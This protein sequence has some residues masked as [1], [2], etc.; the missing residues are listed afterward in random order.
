MKWH[1]EQQPGPRDD[2]PQAPATER[3]SVRES[4]SHPAAK[5]ATM[6]A[7]AAK[8][9]AVTAAVTHR[10]QVNDGHADRA[11]SNIQSLLLQLTDWGLAGVVLVLPFVMGGRLAVGHIILCGLACIIAIAWSLH[12]FL[13]R[14][15][16]YRWSGAEPILLAGVGLVALQIVSLPAE[17]LERLSPKIKELIPL[18]YSPEHEALGLPRWTTLSLVPNET[19]G[20]LIVLLAGVLVL[21]VCLQ[22]LR[23]LEDLRRVLTWCAWSTLLMAAFG[24]V[25]LILANGKFY[26]F[27]AHPMT[28]TFGA[29]KGAFTNANHYANFIAMGIPIWLWMLAESQAAPDEQTAAK[30]RRHKHEEWH[31]SGKKSSMLSGIQGFVAIVASGTIGLGLLLSQSRGGLIVGCGGGMVTLALLWMQRCLAS[32]TAF[33]MCCVGTVAIAG[34]AL[35]GE[36]VSNGIEANFHQL[37]AVDLEQLD[38]GQVRRQIWEAAMLGNAD[39]PWIGTGVS[40]HSEVYWKYYNHPQ[41]GTEAS[42]AESGYFQIA[43]EGGVTGLVVIGLAI[44]LAGWWCISG[45]RRHWKSSEG[46]I[47]SVVASVLI[48][49]LVHSITDFVW[50]A[51]GC[52]ALVIVCAACARSVATL[53]RSDAPAQ[54]EPNS[55]WAFLTSTPVRLGWGGVAVAAVA[56]AGWSL[57]IKMAQANAEENWFAFM[58]IEKNELPP[59]DEAGREAQLLAETKYLLATVQ[60]DPRDHRAQFRLAQRCLALF[61]ARQM[62][63]DSPFPLVHFRD[64]ALAMPSEAREEWLQRPAVIGPRMKYLDA[65]WNCALQSLRH[66]PLQSRVYLQLLDIGWLHD[67]EPQMESALLAQAQAARP[68][69]AAVHLRLGMIA[70]NEQQLEEG[71]AHFQEA[72][73]R[74]VRYRLPMLESMHRQFPANFFLENFDLDVGLLAI[75]QTLYQDS[76]DRRGYAQV[77]AALAA[78]SAENAAELRGEAAINEWLRAFRS[79]DELAMDQEADNAIRNAFRLNPNS[80]LLRRAMAVWDFDH[81]RYVEAA[82]HYRWCYRQDPSDQAMRTRADEATRLAGGIT[83]IGVT[84]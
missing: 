76:E 6:P 3:Q 69:D 62:E 56:F 28:T 27:Y 78:K 60:A 63:S 15:P 20:S 75:L 1:F 59:D 48:I 25:Q 23:T 8:K 58:R 19:Q 73:A 31:L 7:V 2:A 81:H 22:R 67:L 39:F 64:A 82:E 16:R 24:I 10:R 65:A 18:W 30:R 45:M 72:F 54:A 71:L 33:T 77:V 36:S 66:C 68:Y 43:L 47:A 55:K 42:H 11:E 83:P 61:H 74:D 21:F 29:A 52:M 32:R 46:A 14:A 53:P 70:W 44:L 12:Q 84:Q 9:P 5:P 4:A 26:W 80:E 79:Y 50:Y 40:S 13:D 35:F 38:E 57:P 17:W 41:T 51:P 49:D 37:A 34:I